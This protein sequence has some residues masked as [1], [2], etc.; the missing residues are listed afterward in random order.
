E[1]REVDAPRERVAQHGV[2]ACL[3]CSR[4]DAWRRLP[5]T[6]GLHHAPDLLPR[7]GADGVLLGGGDLQPAPARLLEEELLAS[8]LLDRG[9]QLVV[10]GGREAALRLRRLRPD[11][12]EEL[13]GGECPA[14]VRRDRTL[15]GATPQLRLR[16][17]RQL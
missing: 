12:L 1:G 17:V 6:R 14:R 3:D 7:R 11:E 15:R 4:G 8:E 2:H 9:G 10:G 5:E 16:T 13:A